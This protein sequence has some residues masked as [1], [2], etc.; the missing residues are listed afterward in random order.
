MT[1]TATGGTGARAMTATQDITVT[2]NDVDETPA[3]ASVDVTSTPSA[4]ADTY[5]LGETIEVTVTF[6]QAVTVTGAPSIELRI[7]RRPT[8]PSTSSWADLRRRL[9]GPCHAPVFDYV[10]QSGDMDDNGIWHQGE[11]TG[12]Q[13]RDDPGR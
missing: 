11:Q 9:Q 5:G 8:R 3:V 4:T 10:V 12:A 1:V 7:G 2:V 6:D 13:R